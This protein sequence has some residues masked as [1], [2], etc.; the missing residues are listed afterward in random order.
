MRP[1]KKVCKLKTRKMNWEKRAAARAHFLQ[2]SSCFFFSVRYLLFTLQNL[3]EFLEKAIKSRVH[4][5]YKTLDPANLY[6]KQ[7]MY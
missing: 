6:L 1:R 5:D 3:P 7:L 2:S 4:I